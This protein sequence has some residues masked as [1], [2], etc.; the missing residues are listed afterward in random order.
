MDGLWAYMK[1]SPAKDELVERLWE[2]C[3]ESVRMCCDGHLTRLCNVLCGFRE[4]FK[5]PV[6]V[7]EL[8]Q[9]RMAVIAEKEI[10]V[11]DKVG[12]AWAVFEELSVPMDQREAWVE[13]F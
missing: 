11:E 7:G 10:P 4:E 8:L 5:P 13:A 1:T 9:Q 3:Y 12:E 6:S 2:E